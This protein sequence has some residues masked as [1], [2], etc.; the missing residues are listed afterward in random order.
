MTK[1]ASG[2][3]RQT[4][5]PNTPLQIAGD[6]FE[7]DERELGAIARFITEM[8]AARRRPLHERWC[9][10]V[11]HAKAAD[12]EPIWD[13]PCVGRMLHV[14]DVAG[15]WHQ[16]EPGA[17]PRFYFDTSG[18]RG[19]DP[20]EEELRAVYRLLMAG[21]RDGLLNV[22]TLALGDLDDGAPSRRHR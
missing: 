17:P 9:D 4:L 14:G 2:T 8:Q 22:A 7:V 21:G 20:T 15:W 13:T 18:P 16:D 11:Q 1:N 12:G 6:V 3:H 5:H 19:W 10:P